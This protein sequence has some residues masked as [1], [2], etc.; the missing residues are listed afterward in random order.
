MGGSAQGPAPDFKGAALAEGQASQQAIEQQ[1]W[2]NRP[3]QYGPW[4]STT[5]GNQEVWD[6]SSEQFINQWTQ[7]TQ[8]DPRLQSGLDAQFK[9]MQ[10]QSEAGNLLLQR[11]MQGLNQ[12][13]DYSQFGGQAG[14]DYDPTQ[15]RQRAEDNIYMQGAGR[16][17]PQFSGMRDS[18]E[19]NLRNKGLR[20]GD[21][22]Y[23]SEM[24]RINMQQN[25]A[26]SQLQSQAISGG[27]SEAAQMW[28]QQVGGA[29]Y[30]NMMRSNAM[31]EAQQQRNQPFNEYMAMRSGTQINNPQF[32]PYQGA[33]RAQAPNLLGAMQAT[34]GYNQNQANASAAQSQ[35]MMQGGM[36]LAAMAMFCDRRL[37]KNIKRV[38]T[39]KGYPLYS[40]DYLWGESA[41]GPMSD[42]VNA[43]AVFK[44]ESGFD[45]V[46]LS[47]LE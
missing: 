3:D 30:A 38:G 15:I 28:Q 8:L 14:L 16:L 33:G 2:A 6:P 36:S 32:N 31:N 5:W 18:A 23:E 4:G 41:I 29:D 11:S 10:G 12:P 26:M 46:D 40:F 21:Q 9:S 37:K 25:D 22:A 42:E 47:R 19:I 20:P 43:E 44:H 13:M 24:N 17:N 34:S 39:I 35:N 27:Q 7:N 45:M 1:T